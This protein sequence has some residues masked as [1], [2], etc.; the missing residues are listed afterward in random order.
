MVRLVVAHD[1]LA[2]RR[3][4]YAVEAG[5]L[6][7]R[8]YRHVF[9]EALQAAL[10]REEPV[11]ERSLRALSD[12]FDEWLGWVETS[13]S[14]SNGVSRAHTQRVAFTLRQ[15]YELAHPRNFFWTNAEALK[16]TRQQSGAN[17]IRGLANLLE[18][19]SRSAPPNSD[20]TPAAA[21]MI[22]KSLATTAGQVVYQNQL[23]ELIQYAPTTPQVQSEPVLIV[24]AWIMKYYI[25]DLSP[26]NSLI[27]YLVAN[28]YTV[29]TISW[30]NPDKTDKEL[31]FDDYRRL[32]VLDALEAISAI[33]PDERVHG[34]GY[35]LG[36]TLLSVAAAG[37][38]RDGNDPLASLTLL[39]AQ[40]DFRDAGELS[41]FIDEAQLAAL[42]AGMENSGFLNGDQMA[43]AFTLLRSRD[44]VWRKMQQSYLLGQREQLA[45]LMVWNE[46]KTRMPYRM[47]SEY[48][49][50]FFL[51]N[52]FVQGRLDVDGH[53][54]AVS[55][56]RAPIFAL[57]TTKDH[58]APWRSVFKIHLFAD[59]EVTFALTN[60]GHN[61]GVVS[62][63]DHPRRHHHIHTK[64]DC[65]HY[66]DP[67]SWLDIA[68]GVEGSWW[69][70][71]V[72]W[73]S[74]KSTGIVDARLPQHADTR[75]N[76][77]SETA[78]VLLAP[79]NNIVEK[80]CLKDW[81]YRWFNF[82]N[83]LGG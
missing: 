55:D 50:K 36:G 8:A 43:A 42:D 35:C 71:W 53:P 28:G 48:L 18:D 34:V 6:A 60:G 63:A 15:A 45:D 74:S 29:F 70:S 80:L 37:L 26:E 59:T 3:T 12:A 67:D 81:A 69:P 27:S 65:E 7:S 68:T 56:I 78:P 41:L 58:V 30:R 16:A 44:L 39:A 76:L 54:V 21:Q 4:H 83:D 52:D 77:I 57:G 14:S 46:D 2:G 22:G 75:S 33:I 72:D 64:Q 13:L 62:P 20:R 9:E 31:S 32:G 66:V 73:L 38:A 11:A 10:S 51:N 61:A 49:R 25:L 40:T 1:V 24:P 17:L 19:I 82:S 23:I 5:Q 47:H 79:G